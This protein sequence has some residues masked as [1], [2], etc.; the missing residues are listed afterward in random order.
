MSR[1]KYLFDPPNIVVHILYESRHIDV[2]SVLCRDGVRAGLLFGLGDGSRR[3]A[4]LERDAL[5]GV[6]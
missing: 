2:I 6:L 4:L 5:G 1:A 3:V